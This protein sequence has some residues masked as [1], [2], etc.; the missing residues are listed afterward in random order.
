M[1]ANLQHSD[2]SF[3]TLK[4]ADLRRCSL[5]GVNFTSSNMSGADLTGADL[6]DAALGGAAIDQAI[7]SGSNWWE[8]NFDSVFVRNSTDR[9][10]EF[11]VSVIDN[12]FDKFGKDIQLGTRRR[13]NK[14]RKCSPYIDRK[15]SELWC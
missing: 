13:G 10:V 5:V 9:E 12:L 14:T 11:R 3:S 15:L 7:L 6:T 1:E 2:F 8:A 4:N